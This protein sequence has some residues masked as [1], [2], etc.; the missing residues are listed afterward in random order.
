MTPDELKLIEAEKVVFTDDE[1]FAL[2]SEQHNK[3]RHPYT[4]GCNSRHRPLIATRGGWRCADC[5]Y[6]QDWAHDAAGGLVHDERLV[7]IAR[8][9][10]RYLTACDIVESGEWP[11]S[12]EPAKE[13]VESEVA[14]RAALAKLESGHDLETE[15]ANLRAAG[16]GLEACL[17]DSLIYDGPRIEENSKNA[18]NAWLEAKCGNVHGT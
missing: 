14:L 3:N 18:L 7:A 15:N 13:V 9:A 2:N 5:D 1:C 12:H 16:D 11:E 4:C 10:R 6:K 8:A 17:C